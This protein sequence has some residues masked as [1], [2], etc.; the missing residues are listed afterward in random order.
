M[1]IPRFK[2]RRRRDLGRCESGCG[3]RVYLSR[4]DRGF[5]TVWRTLADVKQFAAL[6]K[7]CERTGK[8]EDLGWQLVA[9]EEEIGIQTTWGASGWW[10]GR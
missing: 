7:W 6:V 2:L 3:I 1:L 10:S 8:I 9:L 4:A 5:C